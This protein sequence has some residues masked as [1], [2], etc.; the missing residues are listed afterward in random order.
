MVEID[1]DS[2]FV[3]IPI[4]CGGMVVMPAAIPPCGVPGRFGF[5]LSSEAFVRF[6]GLVKVQHIVE[7]PMEYVQQVVEACPVHGASYWE[8]GG[9]IFTGDLSRQVI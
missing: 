6:R 2:T 7:E 9:D 8:D 1:K 4:E 5:T 3:S